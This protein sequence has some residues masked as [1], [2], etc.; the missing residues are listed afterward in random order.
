MNNQEVLLLPKDHQ[1]HKEGFCGSSGYVEVGHVLF[2]LFMRIILLFLVMKFITGSALMPN[3]LKK[4]NYGIW[5][6]L[7]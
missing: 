6:L 2:R 3:S 1:F 7:F 5:P 4:T